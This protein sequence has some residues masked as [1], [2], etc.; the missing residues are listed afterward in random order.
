MSEATNTYGSDIRFVTIDAATIENNIITSLEN[1]VGEVLYPGD[2]RRLFGQGIVSVFVS[3]NS[4]L[5]DAGRQ[6]LLVYARGEVLDALGAR[7]NC[8]RLPGAAATTTIRFSVMTA[9]SS[10]IIIPAGTRITSDGTI[11]FATNAVS[12]LQAGTLYVDVAT[13]CTLKGD[14]Y[15]DISIGAL[16]TLVDLIPYIATVSN[17]TVTG[18]GDDGEPYTEDGD[19]KYRARIRLSPAQWS[20]AGPEISYEYYV[21]SADPTIIDAKIIS[22]VETLERS[23]PVY[24]GIAYKGGER[25]LIDTLKV[26]AHESSTPAVIETDYLINYQDDLLMIATMPE[27][28][29]AT[30]TELDIEID[31]TLEGRVKIVPLLAGGEIPDE[32]VIAK[33]LAIVN[34]EEIRPLTDYV[35]VVAPSA[36]EYDIEFKYYTTAASEAD[37]ITA[38]EGTGGAIDKYKTWQ[39]TALGRDINPDALRLFVLQAGSL[40]IDVTSP[41]RTVLRDDQVA[42]WSGTLNVS[43]EVI[44]GVI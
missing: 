28:S 25:L 21:L 35:T 39:S 43:H 10:N 33:I 37:M 13:S 26:Y 15:N 5:D 17:T 18:G 16:N 2:E 38:I 24:S 31:N 8:V 20:T 22:E 30:E 9:R 40:M 23:L 32:T 6:S 4:S 42:K 14:A 12:V 11:Y 44:S 36:V 41:T 1:G 7:T 34:D 3:L 27:G 19:N 29:L